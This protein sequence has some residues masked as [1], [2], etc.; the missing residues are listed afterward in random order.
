MWRYITYSLTRYLYFGFFLTITT[1]KLQKKRFFENNYI[2]YY[3]I[4]KSENILRSSDETWNKFHS[5]F[6]GYKS[7][8]RVNNR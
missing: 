4:Y 6:N 8:T 5:F 3:S 7:F 1:N 2:D